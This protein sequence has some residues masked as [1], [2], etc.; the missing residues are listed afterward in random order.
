MPRATVGYVIYRRVGTSWVVYRRL[1]V[2]TDTSGRAR[3]A[4]RFSLPGSW[5]V[6]SSAAATTSNGSSGWSAIARYE[7]R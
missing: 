1:A 3:L 5:Y 6:R 4:W 7:V 2:T